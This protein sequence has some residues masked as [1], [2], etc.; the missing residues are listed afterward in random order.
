MSNIAHLT[1]LENAIAAIKEDPKNLIFELNA[2]NSDYGNAYIVAVPYGS[3]D[4]QPK[5]CTLDITILRP[6][7][8]FCYSGALCQDP[9]K[10]VYGKIGTYEPAMQVT[11]T[12]YPLLKEFFE[13]V[14]E[15]FVAWANKLKADNPTA[16]YANYQVNSCVKTVYSA[17]CPD[18]KLRGKAREP[19]VYFGLKFGKKFPANHPV[20]N[21]RNAPMT[22]IRRVV[23]YDDEL[24][25]GKFPIFEVKTKPNSN[26]KQSPIVTNKKA[27]HE[28]SSTHQKITMLRFF[29]SNIT[30]ASTVSKISLSPSVN[31]V[32]LAPNGEMNQEDDEEQ[33]NMVAARIKK[34]SDRAVA[35]KPTVASA[36]APIHVIEEEEEPADDEVPA[37]EEDDEEVPAP[38]IAPKKKPT[39]IKKAT[40]APKK[41]VALKKVAPPV[42][43]DEE[44]APVDEDEEPVSAPVAVFKKPATPAPRKKLVAPPVEEDEE[45]APVDED[46]E[47]PAPAP[48][49]KKTIKRPVKK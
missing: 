34:S 13:L 17:D 49:P 23:E 26:P 24:V 12:S 38:V 47:E 11:L 40:T 20:P 6:D 33:T 41:T 21:R 18:E 14:T 44:D 22:T 1:T 48:A 45:E 7:D 16:R 2:K 29:M 35:K 46:D 9:S 8:S 25:D 36:P 28:F 37:E 5:K 19:V 27:L 30:L 42:E 10:P 15:Q 43:E 4:G 31:E 39:S 32:H 3:K